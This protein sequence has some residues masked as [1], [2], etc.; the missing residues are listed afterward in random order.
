MNEAATFRLG[1]NQ[2][3]TEAAQFLRKWGNIRVSPSILA[4]VMKKELYIKQSWNKV[5]NIPN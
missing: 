1:Y 4:K 3:I 5:Y 2:G